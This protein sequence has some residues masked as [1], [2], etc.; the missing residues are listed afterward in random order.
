MKSIYFAV[1]AIALMST[2]SVLYA[3]EL[4]DAHIRLASW[5]MNI[6]QPASAGTYTI[7]TLTPARTVAKQ[8][9]LRIIRAA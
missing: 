6:D 8:A 7:Q 4:E 9:M 5:F 3:S 1:C 2:A